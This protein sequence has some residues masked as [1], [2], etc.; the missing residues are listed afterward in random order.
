MGVLALASA[1]EL[2]PD[3]A[4]LGWLVRTG[5]AEAGWAHRLRTWMLGQ[6]PASASEGWPWYPGAAAWV[7][8]T[9]MAV[10]A[11]EA[12]AAVASTEALGKRLESARAFLLERRCADGGWNHGSSR[13]L[14]YDTDSYPETTGMALLAL[15]GRGIAEAEVFAKA[16][17]TAWRHLTATRSLE[18]WCWLQMGLRAHRIEPPKVEPPQAAGRQTREIALYILTRSMM[19]GNN[20]WKFDTVRPA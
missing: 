9:A 10:L 17:E 5:G 11:A 14:G 1:G 8:P 12:A 18:G 13:A 20:P 7:G 3:D 6:E 15:A 19:E 4:A 16:R 2:R